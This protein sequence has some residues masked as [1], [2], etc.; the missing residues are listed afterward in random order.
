VFI[1][2]DVIFAFLNIF[3]F[4]SIFF[5]DFKYIFSIFLEF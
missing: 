3:F 4:K 2:K 5:C 1:I